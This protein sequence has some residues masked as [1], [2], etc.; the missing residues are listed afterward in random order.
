VGYAVEGP[1]MLLLAIRFFLVRDAIPAVN[2]I[3][4]VAGVGMAA[5]LW[6]ALDRRAEPRHPLVEALRLA[7][8]TLF[9]GVALYAG[10][11]VLFYAAPLA[12][13]ALK[14]YWHSLTHLGDFW[15]E[16]WDFIKNLWR[17]PAWIPFTALGLI[18]G[19][20]TATL[21]V[22]MPVAVPLLAVR[23]WLR[24]LRLFTSRAGRIPALALAVGTLAVAALLF[25]LSLRQ[26]QRQAFALLEKPP[27][28]PQ[29]ARAL[30][31]RA[32]TLR[33]GLLNAYLAPFRYLSAVGEVRHVRDLYRETF[34]LPE[35]TAA[36]VQAAYEVVV[37]PLL[38]VPA[39]PPQGSGAGGVNG[40][41]AFALS[42]EPQQAAVLYER[43]FDRPILEGER[44][45][46]VRAVRSTWSSEQ[47]AGAWQAVDDREIY[48]LQQELTVAEHGDWAEVELYEVYQNQ[49]VERQEVVYYFSLPESAVITGVWLGDGPD[50]S[51]R[52]VYRVSPRGAAQTSYKNQVQRR[53]DPALVE[54]I[55]P[56]QYRLRVFPIPPRSFDR[57]PGSNRP[58]YTDAPPLYLWL[59]YRVF[60]R[61]GAWPLPQLAEKRNVYWN[62]KTQRQI[63]GRPMQVEAE[64]WLPA[65]VPAGNSPP[66]A[67][68]RLDFP[69]GQTVLAVPAAPET[70]FGVPDPQGLRLAV[71]L[72][73]SLSMSEISGQVEA[74]FDR[75][76]EMEASGASVDV[77]LTASAYRGEA[78]VRLPLADLD[79]G[80]IL[81]FGG[82][83]AAELLAQFDELR[84]ESLYQAVLVLTDGTGYALGEGKVEVPVPG[85]PVW[86]VH[87]GGG[88]PLGYD[89]PTLAAI[90]A[91]GGG[92]AGSLDEA[93][94]RLAFALSVRVESARVDF[95]DGYEWTTL[96]TSAL[97]S[98]PWTRDVPAASPAQDGFAALAARRLILAEMHKH[99]GALDGLP[100]LDSLHAIA[101]ERSIV[102]PYSS[103]I[104]LVTEQQHNQLDLLEKSG[105]RFEREVEEV[106]ETP[107]EAP[108][109]VTGVP[110]P[111]EWLLLGLAAALLAWGALRRRLAFRRVE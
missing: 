76:T 44:E 43:F 83:N 92:V 66:A 34:G 60:A 106:G 9:L 86:M 51:T 69:N 59:T 42:R 64:A 35:E 73:R 14:W 18:L 36:R 71:V 15:R 25:G 3:L 7:G 102:T 52:F 16:A 84:G 82:Q 67:P 97:E 68:H 40:P 30:L 49:T 17:D 88:L 63:D 8:L 96:P 10:V 28:S 74:A 103:M 38:Y 27:A 95:V 80:E 91:S 48:L 46:V 105:D 12:F 110:E 53:L 45:A 100:V 50:R 78:P 81:Y 90:Q 99:R 56:R 65:S 20:Y 57:E 41:E 93:L 72:D 98:L 54:Q 39:R 19:L 77:Y 75:L 85:A 58:R 107:L 70:Y 4:G 32:E 2:L 79:P 87:L 101:M 1:L 47:A 29:E 109:A 104:V 33:Q 94:A 62:G 24:G 37:R 11:W 22:L 13:M 89:D 55:G 26:P 21:F 108:F 31:D 5:F 111:E 6:S 61:E 23:A